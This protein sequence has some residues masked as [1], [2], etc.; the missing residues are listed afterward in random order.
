MRRCN[1]L[2]LSTGF[3]SVLYLRLV[4]IAIFRYGFSLFLHIFP[5]CWNSFS[6][7]LLLLLRLF[8]STK[9]RDYVDRK[10]WWILPASMLLLCSLNAHSAQCTKH[11]LVGYHWKVHKSWTLFMYS[12]G[13]SWRE[14]LQ[15]ETQAVAHTHQTVTY[16]WR[17]IH[18]SWIW[19]RPEN[20]RFYCCCCCLHQH[21]S[22]DAFSYCVR[23]DNC[24]S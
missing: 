24:I 4:A 5:W 12:H 14:P 10:C 16:N 3:N 1:F 11:I 15:R 18:K 6:F 22:F 2:S 13:E 7:F 9:E 17:A 20:L 8:S 23:A 19:Q 21:H